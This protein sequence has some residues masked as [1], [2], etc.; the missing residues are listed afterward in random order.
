MKSAPCGRRATHPATRSAAN[1]NE[2]RKDFMVLPNR[3]Q[4]MDRLGPSANVSPEN[5]PSPGFPLRIMALRARKPQ[6]SVRERSLLGEGGDADRP[7]AGVEGRTPHRPP[8]A[9]ETH[10]VQVAPPPR[11]DHRSSPRPSGKDQGRHH[12][13]R[14]REGKAA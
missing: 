4:A 9:P 3:Q 14:D 6:G 7:D 11:Q 5:A 12:P 1:I 2:S 8:R 10:H 13:A